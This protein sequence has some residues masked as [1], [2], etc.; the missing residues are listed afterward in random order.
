MSSTVPTAR[1]LTDWVTDAR[2]RTLELIADLDDS[3]LLGPRLAIVN[4]L[5]GV[6]D[7]RALR[8]WGQREPCH[9]RGI[10]G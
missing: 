1:Q 6:A 5:L 9:R 2:R 10:R 4:P 8:G 7:L 3:Q